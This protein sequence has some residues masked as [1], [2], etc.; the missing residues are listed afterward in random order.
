MEIRTIW[1]KEVDKNNKKKRTNRYLIESLFFT[2]GMS[3]LDIL[4]ILASKNKTVFSFTDNYTLNYVVTVMITAILLFI[5]SFI[6]NYFITE[7]KIKTK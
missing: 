6:F 2:L 3:V 1:G 4:L 7:N 5:I